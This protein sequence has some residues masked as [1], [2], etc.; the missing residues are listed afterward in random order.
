MAKYRFWTGGDNTGGADNTDWAQAY[1]TFAGAVAAA[2]SSGDKILVH[3]T[4]QESLGAN[5]TWTLSAGVDVHVVD[6][7][8]SEAPATM[9]TGGWIGGDVNFIFKLTCG[10][11]QAHIVT[12]LTMRVGGA[13]SRSMILGGSGADGSHWELE[14][15]YFWTGNTNA[16][17]DLV[18]GD[19]NTEQYISLTRCTFRFGNT[20]QQID[21]RSRAELESGDISSAG[22]APANLF[23]TS[24]ANDLR[25]FDVTWTGGDLSH[26]GSGNIVLDGQVSTGRL[27]LRR[28][29]LGTS[30]VLLSTSATTN[31]NVEVFAYD[32]AS[33]DSHIHIAH[34]NALG[35]TVV[36]TGIYVTADAE[37]LS[38][39]IT[40]TANADFRSPYC[41]PWV[42]RYNDDVAT[43]IQ[44][45]IEV[46]RD[47]SATAYDDDEIYGVF[48][49]KGTSG[50]TQ[51]TI[52]DDRMNVL[53][54]PAAQ[55]TGTGTGNWTGDTSAWSGKVQAP[56][57]FTPAEIGDLRSRV[58]VS[59]ASATLYVSPRIRIA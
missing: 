58:C 52:V 5:A 17:T 49:Y 14:D 51:A 13:S 54:T 18:I 28:C 34:Q 47:G 37:V 32:C 12:G 41:S 50:S 42:R 1:N 19:D 46:L 31:A 3:K 4:S 25:K 33:T 35:S 27:I 16:S 10:T 56:S 22:S 59:L 11:N 39:K 43:S 30:F 26:V 38:W 40:T 24:G 55:A 48:A 15:V 21:M 29:K 8:S 45:W 20:A 2:T 6:K 36:D 44:P 53:G 9:G 23:K 7:D 57:A